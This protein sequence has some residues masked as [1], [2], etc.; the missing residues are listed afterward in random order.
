MNIAPLAP[1]GA[2]IM[3]QKADYDITHDERQT[4]IAIGETILTRIGDLDLKIASKNDLMN[5][6]DVCALLKVNPKQLYY[7]RK[8]YDFPY[9]RASRKL[10]YYKQSDII[11]WLD[12]YR[13]TF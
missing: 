8:K 6:H 12:N 2:S 4:F 11:K 1:S 3:P 10:V 13:K 7:L 5:S 9:Y